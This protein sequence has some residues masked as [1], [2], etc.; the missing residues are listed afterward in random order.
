MDDCSLRH[1]VSIC[2]ALWIPARSTHPA[3]I[4]ACMVPPAPVPADCKPQA[5]SQQREA[6]RHDC[7]NRTEPR[8]RKMKCC[9]AGRSGNQLVAQ[10]GSRADHGLVC[11][12][13]QGR[14][15][16]QS[17]WSTGRGRL[18]R[19]KRCSSRQLRIP[20]LCMYL[21]AFAMESSPSR[22]RQASC[23]CHGVAI[24]FATGLSW[25]AP[26]RSVAVS[27][28]EGGTR[29]S[30]CD[31]LRPASQRSCAALRRPDPAT[32]AA[33]WEGPSGRRSIGRSPAASSRV[34]DSA[35]S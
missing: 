35:A 25:G 22:S 26:G 15:A 24:A 14:W 20:V 17:M 9:S 10:R 1:D 7:T 5:E 11:G 8:G 2:S 34:Q 23:M 3:D 27:S 32:I 29:H 30:N 12:H 33:Q 18:Q 31:A 21:P 6:A 4:C 19:C 28:N 13:A 16:Q